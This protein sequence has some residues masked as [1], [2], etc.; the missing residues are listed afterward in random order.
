L[1]GIGEAYGR[2]PVFGVVEKA[3][4]NSVPTQFCP[5]LGEMSSFD[6]G[7]AVCA[8]L[9]SSVFHYTHDGVPG[10]SCGAPQTQG[11]VPQAMGSLADA[12]GLA[13]TTNVGGMISQIQYGYHLR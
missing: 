12:S 7:R 3:G 11:G 6:N 13:V 2:D 9:F 10:G 8:T 1:Q 5:P 4:F